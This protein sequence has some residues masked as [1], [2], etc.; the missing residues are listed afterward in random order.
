MHAIQSIE[1]DTLFRLYVGHKCSHGYH[2]GEKSCVHSTQCLKKGEMLTYVV[3]LSGRMCSYTRQFFNESNY[4]GCYN[5]GT[6][7]ARQQ[8]Y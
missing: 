8:N 6:A 2:A 7:K 3:A 1:L 5:H 4:P